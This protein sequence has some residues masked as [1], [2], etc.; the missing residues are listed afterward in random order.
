M[1][2]LVKDHVVVKAGVVQVATE[3]ENEADDEVIE[4]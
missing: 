4:V 2:E 3:A 1:E